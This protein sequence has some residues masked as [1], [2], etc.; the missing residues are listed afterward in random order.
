[1]MRVI[2][3]LSSSEWAK[4]N[5]LDKQT[6]MKRTS[7]SFS[8]LK[9]VRSESTKHTPSE[10]DNCHTPSKNDKIFER[11]MCYQKKKEKRRDENQKKE[12]R[13]F[14]QNHHIFIFR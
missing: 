7:N 13:D 6:C 1:M 14:A 10:L 8:I 5:Y 2:S 4:A 3:N 11:S 9:R 12:K